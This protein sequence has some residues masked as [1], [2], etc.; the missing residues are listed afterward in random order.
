MGNISNHID[1]VLGDFF[2][3]SGE[4]P[5]LSGGNICVLDGHLF[6]EVLTYGDGAVFKIVG[7]GEDP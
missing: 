4:F 6:H 2:V 5:L 7:L 1:D 3:R